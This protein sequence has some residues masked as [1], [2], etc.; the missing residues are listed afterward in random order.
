LQTFEHYILE[1]HNLFTDKTLDHIVY[2][3]KQ[4]WDAPDKTLKQKLTVTVFINNKVNI[5][6]LFLQLHLNVLQ[7]KYLIHTTYHLPILWLFILL[8]RWM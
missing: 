3:D 7:V 2:I 6:E 8:P 5:S 1:R 4:L